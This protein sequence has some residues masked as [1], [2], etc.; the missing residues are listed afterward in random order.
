L[1]RSLTVGTAAVVL[2]LLSSPVHAQDAPDPVAQ[3]MANADRLTARRT[4]AQCRREAAA[5]LDRGDPD[6]IV[7][8]PAENYAP[9]IPELYGPV[10]GSTDGRAVDPTE[11]CG[12]SLQTPCF[13]GVDVLAA[14]RFVGGKILDLFDPDRD[15]G[16]GTPIPDRFRGANR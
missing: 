5:A 16:A 14:V 3:A 12:L 7:C 4:N 9:P 10:Y 15:L 11:P 2:A 13:E 6:I 8:A 1:S